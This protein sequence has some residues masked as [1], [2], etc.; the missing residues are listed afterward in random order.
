MGRADRRHPTHPAPEPPAQGSGSSAR[1]GL[2]RCKCCLGRVDVWR[3]QGSARA[4]ATLRNT[5]LTTL[6]RT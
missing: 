1:H 5:H 4:Q 2:A 6:L 3:R